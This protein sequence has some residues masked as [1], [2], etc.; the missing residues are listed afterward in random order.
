M[1]ISRAENLV[2]L[3]AFHCASITTSSVNSL[4]IGSE[5]SET[6]WM[7]S[8]FS[9]PSWCSPSSSDICSWGCLWDAE[10]LD[11]VGSSLGGL[12]TPLQQRVFAIP[13]LN[14]VDAVPRD[15]KMETLP[16]DWRTHWWWWLCRMP[17]NVGYYVIWIYMHIYANTAHSGLLQALNST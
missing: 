2:L 8:S 9:T 1:I 6:K 13:L 3:L 12:T 4:I 7:S 15:E 17:G 16:I 11:I 5:I 14:R 10:Q